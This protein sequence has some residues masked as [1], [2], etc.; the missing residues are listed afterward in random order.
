MGVQG[1][2]M[3]TCEEYVLGELTAAQMENEKLKERVAELEYENGHLHNRLGQM[4]PEIRR[5]S[6]RNYKLWNELCDI[7]HEEMLDRFDV[8]DDPDLE[9]DDA[10]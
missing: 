3:R 8:Y 4:E 7:K 10:Q 2:H 6:E 9:V 1:L 5:L